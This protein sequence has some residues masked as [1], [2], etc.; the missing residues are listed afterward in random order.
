[1]NMCAHPMWGLG[2]KWISKGP[3]LVEDSNRLAKKVSMSI[4]KIATLDPL[5]PFFPPA[6]D[7]MYRS[8]C[9]LATVVGYRRISLEVRPR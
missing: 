7:R 9:G 3:K 6:T 4:I 2:G 5:L 1:M 8:I